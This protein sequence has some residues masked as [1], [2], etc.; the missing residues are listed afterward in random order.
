MASIQRDVITM[1]FAGDYCSACT[2]EKQDTST[3]I[4]GNDNIG[5]HK[6]LKG[7]KH[8][9]RGV[10]LGGKILSMSHLLSK[11]M[12]VPGGPLLLQTIVF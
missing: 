3:K 10:Q 4:A 2:A 9:I 8:P 6:K 12:S 11:R 5:S 7:E 1:L